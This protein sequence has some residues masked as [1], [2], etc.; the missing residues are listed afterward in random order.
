MKKYTPV[1]TIKV[2]CKGVYIT[3]TCYHY[4]CEIAPREKTKR[5]KN[6]TRKDET[7]K[8]CHAKRRNNDTRCTKMQKFS[9][10]RRKTSCEKTNLK[11]LVCRLFALRLASFR[12]FVFSRGFLS[13]FHVAFFRLLRG[14]C[15]SF[16]LPVL[17]RCS[18][19]HR[20]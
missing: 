6:A 2:G 14:V 20:F 12:Y 7:T 3:R 10:K 15:S 1:N 18:V 11:L 16:R 13:S 5:R 8:R 17:M 4:G 19:C 9:A